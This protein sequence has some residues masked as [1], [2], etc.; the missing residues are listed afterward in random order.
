MRSSVNCLAASLCFLAALCAQEEGTPAPQADQQKRPAD[1][2][3]LFAAFAKMPG[4]E[5]RYAEEKH[6]QLLE[7]PLVS[8]GR[9]YFMPPGYLLRAVEAP[10]KSTLL[11]TPKELRMANRDGTEVVDLAQSDRLRVFVTSLVRVFRGD[12]EEL[13]RQYRV[14]YLPVKD[15]ETSWR[16]ELAPRGRPLDQMLQRLVLAGSGFAVTEITVVEPNGDRTV[17]KIDK[18]DPKRTFDK[19]ERKKLFGV[20]DDRPPQPAAKPDGVE[21]AR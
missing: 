13:A 5:A 11:I 4:L 19:D 15:D 17:T 9:L 20:A 14:D 12:A 16:L 10:E 18:A 7:V 2:G 3:A 8:S 1:A 6:L 21:K